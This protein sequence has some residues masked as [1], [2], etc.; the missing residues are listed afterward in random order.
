MHMFIFTPGVLFSQ[1]LFLIALLY[2]F[3]VDLCDTPFGCLFWQE[4]IEAAFGF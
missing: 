4:Y 2:M 3:G 1:A